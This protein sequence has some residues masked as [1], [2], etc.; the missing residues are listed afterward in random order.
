MSARQT[1]AKNIAELRKRRKLSQ[2]QL[3]VELDCDKLTISRWERADRT[4]R[5]DDFDDIAAALRV[6]VARLFRS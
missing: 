6:S 5:V 2:S 3:A 1:L 4:P